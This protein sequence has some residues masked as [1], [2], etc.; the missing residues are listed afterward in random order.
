MEAYLGSQPSPSNPERPSF[1]CQRTAT[2]HLLH[3][4]LCG[5]G[6]LRSVS[7]GHA[8]RRAVGVEQEVIP[9]PVGLARI[10]AL[11]TGEMPPPRAPD[12]RLFTG[13]TT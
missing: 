10:A 13:D 6:G 2:E 4:R 12:T 1:H 7:H 5:T 11:L 9:G 3:A 8:R